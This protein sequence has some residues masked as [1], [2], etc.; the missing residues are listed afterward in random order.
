MIV[1]G[2]KSLLELP[3]ELRLRIFHYV[4]PENPLQVQPADFSG[5]LY[6]CKTIQEEL[7][8]EIC[9][10]LAQ[11]LHEIASRIILMNTGRH[12]GHEIIYTPPTT[13]HGWLNLTVYRTTQRNVRDMLD[14]LVEFHSFGFNTFT[15]AFREDS[16]SCKSA[17]AETSP[18]MN[19]AIYL[20]KRV[21]DWGKYNGYLTTKRLVLDWSAHPEQPGV[22]F[23]DNFTNHIKA[24][25]T[26]EVRGLL[27]DAGN[28]AG[29]CFTRLP[30]KYT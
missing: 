17:R 16:Q 7:E 28:S 1:N 20:A 11:N 4:L 14:S 13:F 27:D 19:G 22:N 26:L 30:T 23:L 5:L 2:A 21:C 3:V 29:M 8:P 25:K 10:A 18:I 9:K 15:V 24:D 12:A 6:S